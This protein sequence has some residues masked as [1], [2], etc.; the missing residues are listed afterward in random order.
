MCCDIDQIKYTRLTKILCQNDY[1]H[2][3][4]GQLMNLFEQNHA[5]F[6]NPISMLYA[7]HKKVKHF[8]QVLDKLPEYLKQNHLDEH[9]Q[10]AIVQV[11]R[12]FNQA[13]P[14]HHQDEEEDF[15]PLLQHYCPDAISDIQL[16]Q[17]QHQLLHTAWDKI[18]HQLNQA[19]QTQLLDSTIDAELIHHYTNT[20]RQHADIEEKWFAR[21]EAIIPT[22]A[23]EKIGLRMADRR[24]TSN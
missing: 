2:K 22:T 8:C 20:Y 9:A 1:H 18:N 15:F 6:D 7:C 4:N 13:A 21:G 17:T 14:L 19:L 16:L 5:S 11:C 23:L 10:Q 12:Y 24:K 3:E